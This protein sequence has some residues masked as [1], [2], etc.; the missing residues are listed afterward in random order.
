MIL[1]E[2]IELVAALKM[3]QEKCHVTLPAAG[4]ATRAIP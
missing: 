2:G 1:E 3:R 4:A